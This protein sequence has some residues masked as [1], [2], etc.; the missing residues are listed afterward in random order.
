[1]CTC[2][3]TSDWNVSQALWLPLLLPVHGI[4]WTSTL[5]GNFYYHTLLHDQADY[6]PFTCLY[7]AYIL[8]CFSTSTAWKKPD[9]RLQQRICISMWPVEKCWTKELSYKFSGW[10]HHSFQLILQTQG[11]LRWLSGRGLSAAED[12]GADSQTCQ[13]HSPQMGSNWS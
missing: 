1:M 5:L 6:T 9:L 12:E 13:T 11:E 7:L 10:D 3:N 8:R 2:S 4:I